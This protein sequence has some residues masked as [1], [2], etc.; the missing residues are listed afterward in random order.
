MEKTFKV[1]RMGSKGDTTEAMTVAQ[2]LEALDQG[3]MVT[4]DDVVV[5]RVEVPQLEQDAELALYHPI[6]G[7]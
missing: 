1:R 5:H 6:S 2:V 3:Y 7:G 4:H